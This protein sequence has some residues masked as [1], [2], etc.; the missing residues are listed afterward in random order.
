[1]FAHE[2]I[3]QCQI[4]KFKSTKYPHKCR[5]YKPQYLHESGV[6]SDENK[7]FDTSQNRGGYRA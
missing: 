2:W 5:I 7:S 3:I 6:K 1:M 4:F